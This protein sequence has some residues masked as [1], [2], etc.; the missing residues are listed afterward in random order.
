MN[1]PAPA[2]KTYDLRFVV[3]DKRFFWTNPNHGVTIVDA[4]PDSCLTWQTESGAER[5]LWTDISAVTMSSVTDGKAEV[6]QC[7][8]A[9]HGGGSLIVTDTG[10]DGRLDESQTP[11][12]RDFV[13]ALHLRLAQAPQGTITFSAGASESRYLGMKIIL[14]IAALFFVGT[15]FVLLFIVRDWRV[16]GVLAA[17]IAFV[18]VPWTIVQKNKPRSYDPKYPPGELME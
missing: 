14:V 8:I 2:S 1:T 3:N 11:I 17:G 15:P 16:L 5:R 4:G 13:R 12:Y 10:S 18:W 9:F 6:N 7:R